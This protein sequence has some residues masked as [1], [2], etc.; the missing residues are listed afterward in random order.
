MSDPPPV[1]QESACRQQL[2]LGKGADR[3]NVVYVV[4]QAHGKPEEVEKTIFHVLYGRAA[5]AALF[6]G[7]WP[8]KLHRLAGANQ[9]DLQL[10]SRPD[11]RA[12]PRD[13]DGRVA[14]AHG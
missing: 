14:G 8:A 12:A 11:R 7:E 10:R 9:I 6:G 1:L 3:K 2:R 4:Q 13:H 5:T